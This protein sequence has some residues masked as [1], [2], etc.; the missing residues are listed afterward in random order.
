MI[1][2]SGIRYWLLQEVS[3]GGP[4]ACRTN[5]FL[6]DFVAC[7]WCQG[8]Y[9]SNSLS[10]PFRW[11]PLNFLY[12]FYA[13]KLTYTFSIRKYLHNSI[14]KLSSL[15]RLGRLLA[16]W[17]PLPGELR[18]LGRTISVSFTRLMVHLVG[19][20][21]ADLQMWGSCSKDCSLKAWRKF[22]H[23]EPPTYRSGW[24]SSSLNFQG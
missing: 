6:F 9:H 14:S 5:H 12:V 2:F 23:G 7:H 22:R 24:W 19:L 21:A 11:C 16:S 1:K 8:W 13:Y 15:C 18:R 20:K 3:V 17:F 4:N 10:T